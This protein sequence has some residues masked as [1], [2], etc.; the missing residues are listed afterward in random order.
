MQ[1]EEDA[2]FLQTSLACVRPREDLM[3][4]SFDRVWEA[5]L[6]CTVCVAMCEYCTYVCRGTLASS[7][8]I[9]YNVYTS[10]NSKS[11]YC[12]YKKHAVY[13]HSHLQFGRACFRTC[14]LARLLAYVDILFVPSVLYSVYLVPSEYCLI[15]PHS[16]ILIPSFYASKKIHKKEKPMDRTK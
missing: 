5:S 7:D 12:M 16:I 15:I 13:K 11:K 6:L 8:V 4:I 2:K 3:R 14:T 1:R 9:F 10:T